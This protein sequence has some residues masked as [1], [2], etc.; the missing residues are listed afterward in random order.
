MIRDACDAPVPTIDALRD[1][2]APRKVAIRALE[3]AHRRGLVESGG[4]PRDRMV[5]RAATV[6]VLR[7]LFAGPPPPVRGD[8]RAPAIGG[9]PGLYGL[10]VRQRAQRAARPDRHG[11]RD[12]LRDLE[13]RVECSRATSSNAT[14]PDRTADRRAAIRLHHPPQRH[15]PAARLV[16]LGGGVRERRGLG[17]RL[18]VA[19]PLWRADRTGSG[20]SCRNA[21]RRSARRM[22]A[23][24]SYTI[25][26]DAEPR[27]T[28][29]RRRYR[30]HRFARAGPAWRACR[31]V[32][33]GAITH[34]VA[35]AAERGALSFFRRGS[36]VGGVVEHPEELNQDGIDAFYEDFRRFHQGAGEHGER[37]ALAGQREVPADR[38]PAERGAVPRNTPVRTRGESCPG[39]RPGCRTTCSAGGPA[40]RC[41][42]PGSSKQTIGFHTYVLLSRLKRVEEWIDDTLL[43][44]ELQM[45]F[46]VRGLLRAD[47]K[48]R[49]EVLARMRQAGVLSADQWLRLE[50]M[51]PS[52]DRRR[53][54]HTARHAADRCR[55]RARRSRRRRADRSPRRLPRSRRRPHLIGELRCTSGHLL[56]RRVGDAE[57]KC[58]RCGELVR[59]RAGETLR[60][61]DDLAAGTRGGTRRAAALESRRG[62]HPAA[63]MRTP[64]GGCG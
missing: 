12:H 42:A 30:P 35:N 41:G 3:K 22:A 37:A 24:S 9:E 55:E 52:R 59:V 45:R 36:T 23:P 29:R 15:R 60:D 26:D 28:P 1:A 25:E 63:G 16:S 57:I 46:D 21:S 50:D 53:L 32:R 20:S 14:A 11:A 44:R 58:S 61:G 38:H 10:G 19:R 49:S 48:A 56:G 5:D 17:Q 51:P 7:N 64:R 8:W 18:P 27:G 40:P 2:G 6:S 47:S 62:A 43:P 13:G 31:R 39:T 54:P 33:A 34:R 4:V